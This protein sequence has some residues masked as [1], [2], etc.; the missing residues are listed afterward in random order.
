MNCN[1]THWE[2]YRKDYLTVSILT[3]DDHLIHVI[4]P[5][6]VPISRLCSIYQPLHN[7]GGEVG[8]LYKIETPASHGILM[9]FPS[10]PLSTGF[11]KIDSKTNLYISYTVPL[12][13]VTVFKLTGGLDQ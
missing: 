8:T 13:D 2:W 1:V 3:E 6:L 5:S 7:V 4:L 9:F 10:E 12:L 11:R